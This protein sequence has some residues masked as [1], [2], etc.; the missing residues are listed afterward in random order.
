MYNSIYYRLTFNFILKQ[1]I[2]HFFIAIAASNCILWHYCSQCNV[3]SGK[4]QE[5]VMCIYRWGTNR[6]HNC[7]PTDDIRKYFT[8]WFFFITKISYDSNKMS[9]VDHWCFMYS[10]RM[11]R[12]RLEG[13]RAWLVVFHKFNRILKLS[14]RIDQKCHIQTK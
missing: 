11:E 12:S 6:R 8:I 5:F 14:T 7:V 10:T 4:F 13:M 3:E 2:F 9:R 1:N